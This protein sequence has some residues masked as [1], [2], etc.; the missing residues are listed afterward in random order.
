MRRFRM[1]PADPDIAFFTNKKVKKIGFWIPES[2][3]N[4]LTKNLR[5]RNQ[6]TA[7][8]RIDVYLCEDFC[9]CF[10][11]IKAEKCYHV[12]SCNRKQNG[13]FSMIQSFSILLVIFF[14]SSLLAADFLAGLFVFSSLSRFVFSCVELESKKNIFGVLSALRDRAEKNVWCAESNLWCATSLVRRVILW[15]A[16]PPAPYPA[17]K[18]YNAEIGVG[19]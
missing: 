18:K 2:N 7:W 17:P 10:V 13:S 6:R 14:N 16:N 15:C 3:F 12:H 5:F 11:K 1:L 4:S 19:F 9:K 8:F